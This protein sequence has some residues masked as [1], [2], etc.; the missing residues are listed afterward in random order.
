MS[1]LPRISYLKPDYRPD[2]DGLRAIAVLSV[3]GFH[4]FPVLVPGGFIGV[5]I[6][7]VI[8]GFLISKHIWEEL[9]SRTFSIKTF[10]ARRVRRIF[11][12]LAV[13]LFA[14][15]GMGW[16]ILSPGE[17]EQLGKHVEGGA[18]FVS[19]ILYWK[20]AGYFDNAADTKPLLH[21]WSLGIEEQFY[22]AWPL[23]LAFLWRQP[24]HAG[25][26]LPSLLGASF[27]YSM[28]VVRNDTVADF[29]SP[30]TRFWELALGAV[31]AH[32]AI[33]KF[34]LNGLQRE[35]LAWFGLAL[36]VSGI[37]V[38][39]NRA[40]FP[41]AW[42]LLPTVGAAC[43]IQAGETTRLNRQLLSHP[44]LVWVGLISYPLYLW[45]W[46][47]LSFARIMES[48]TPEPAIRLVL[49]AASFVLAWLTWKLVERPIR[50]RPRS[51][52]IVLAL[53][54]AMIALLLTGE[55]V[56]KL[57]GIK[58]RK[59]DMLNGDPATL[60][61]GADRDRLQH[62]CG[63]SES[64]KSLFQYCLRGAQEPRYA[65]LGDSKAEALFYGLVRESPANMQWLMIG[66]VSP[67]GPNPNLENKQELKNHLALQAVIDNPA[68]R[69]VGIAVA[70]RGIFSLD[71]DTGF[72]SSN[73]QPP[74]PLDSYSH[75]V[76]AL[77]HAGKRVVFI[78]D[79]PTFPDPRSCISGGATSSPA[80]NQFLRRKEN[81]HCT[82]SYA[83]HM[84]GTRIYREFVKA[85]QQRHPGL[86][87]YDPAPL[88]CDVPNNVCAVTREGKFLYSY[89]DH[90]SD[91]ANSMIARD[92]VPMIRQL[93]TP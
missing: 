15:L 88:L 6:F 50:S 42:A 49:V 63:L 80:L 66:S 23:I 83:A 40:P 60:V 61:L 46:P 28:M 57:D 86:V 93:D 24:H 91:Y 16:L 55:A 65:L 32:E 7:F 92:M 67:P 43:L 58:T 64:K 31:L 21:L 27:F 47:L 81:P 76:A 33:R 74:P 36:I 12:A 89:G 71:K 78:I 59:L 90:I 70:L 77:E 68:I 35:L 25:W 85:L 10:Y 8:S 41:G 17:Y 18:G 29:Y 13:V 30:L 69:V 53:S 52:S 38:L 54:I 48:A 39:N 62:E 1:Q 22:I 84:E 45:H 72:I 82:V 3:I 73:I 37:V 14:C 44:W 2:I 34:T 4:A 20:E 87:I 11:P 79:N 5:D 51:R 56:R 75:L 9:E 19:N 26:M